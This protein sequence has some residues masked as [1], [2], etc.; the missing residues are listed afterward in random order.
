MRELTYREAIQ[1]ALCQEMRRDPTVFLI[2][3]DIAYL[4]GPYA[5][6]KGMCEE[7]TEERVRDTPISESAIIG[8]AIGA[9][10]NGMRPVAEISLCDFL[11][12]CVDQ[13]VNQAAKYRYSTGG[14]VNLPLVIRTSYGTRGGSGAQHS[15]DLYAMFLNVPGIKIVLPATP[16]DAK[17]MLLASI[18]DPNP[19][20][21]FAHRLLYGLKG[22]VPEDDY[23]VPLGKAQ[24][25]REG[26]DLSIVATGKMVH[27]ALAAADK[28][29]S[30]GARAEV[31]DVRSLAPLDRDTICESVRKTGR[32]L[33]VDEA[34]QTGG[35]TAEIGMSIVEGCFD[36]LD[37]PVVRLGARDFPVPF[38]HAL[39]KSNLPDREAIYQSCLQLLGREE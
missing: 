29:A 10:L 6:T 27:E 28:L 33:V 1:E 34:P 24:V 37:A 21:F 23:V 15:Q 14:S 12:V 36:F 30:D 3:E 26:Q 8:S 4:G 16:Y 20:M 17:G 39:T 32:A 31:V 7:F 5:V 11:M 35:A 22:P 25:I 18:R 13:V 38:N 2:G 19:V 9:S